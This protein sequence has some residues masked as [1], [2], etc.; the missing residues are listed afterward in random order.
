MTKRFPKVLAFGG[1]LFLSFS[2]WGADSRPLA[3]LSYSPSGVQAEDDFARGVTEDHLRTDLTPLVGLTSRIRTYATDNGL[4]HAVPIA[5][6]LGLKV[7][8]GIWLGLYPDVNAAEIHRG[9]TAARKYPGTVDR[10]F[11]GNEVLTRKEMTVPALKAEIAKVKAA[12]KGTNITVG[13]AETWNMWVAH[14]ELAEGLDFIGAHIFPYWDDIPAAEATAYV[15]RRYKELQTLFP[16]QKIVI[17]ETGWPAAGPRRKGAEA[18]P[19]IQAQYVAAFVRA[20]AAAHY[21][22]YI[23]EAYDQPWK[24]TR[25]AGGVGAAWGIMDAAR[26]PKFDVR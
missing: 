17:A 16:N 12:L 9:V 19:A 22:Y 10:V 21:D 18:S 23:V 2:V 15:A 7:S 25:E 6:S 11:V 4:D 5:G 3:G 20:A 8:L 13:T 26:R 24:V 14:P 1:V